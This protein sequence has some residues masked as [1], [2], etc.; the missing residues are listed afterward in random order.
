MCYLISSE[1]TNILDSEGDNFE[2]DK[3]KEVATSLMSLQQSVNQVAPP[4]SQLPHNIPLPLE[5]YTTQ[6]CQIGPKVGQIQ[7]FLKIIFQYIL[8][9]R[10]IWYPCSTLSNGV[11]Q[12]CC[13]YCIEQLH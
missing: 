11:T 8:A 6:E 4:A 13:Q 5:G 10:S 9:C 12:K 7:D 2:G 1:A 3:Y